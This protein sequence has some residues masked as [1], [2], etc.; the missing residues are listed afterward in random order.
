VNQQQTSCC[1][2]LNK[3]VQYRV[4]NPRDCLMLYKHFELLLITY[5]S[6]KQEIYLFDSMFEILTANRSFR[7]RTRC[8]RFS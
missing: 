1:F 6:E 3:L 7:F 5:V 8:S 4:A 2:H